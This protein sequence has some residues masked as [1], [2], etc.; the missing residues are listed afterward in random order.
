MR[1]WVVARRDLEN[2]VDE[3]A[4]GRQLF[5]PQ[6]RGELFEFRP[7]LDFEDLCIDYPTTMIPPSRLFAPDGEVLYR[8]DPTDPGRVESVDR[9][10][11]IALFG[12]HP[13]DLEAISVLDELYLTPPVDRNYGNAR[14]GAFI[15]CLECAAPCVEEALCSDK[16]TF[17]PKRACDLQLV[18][19][20]G[21]EYLVRSRTKAGKSLC[22][23]S[24]FCRSAAYEDRRRL[25][26]F[27]ADQARSFRPVF[28]MGA[29]ELSHNVRGSWD[30]L[31][32]VAQSRLCLNCGACNTV[33]PTCH[34]FTTRDT[35]PLSADGMGERCRHWT[36]CQLEEFAAV[37]GGENFRDHRAF[38]LRHRVYK[39]EVYLVDRFGRSGCVGCGRCGHFCPSGIKLV[40]I[41]GQI[42]GKERARA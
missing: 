7:L 8:F 15:V 2:L 4:R 31:L 1:E 40:E 13:C 5:A 21:D 32:W 3:I 24:D 37:A 41:F 36:G 18:P 29:E 28:G 6:R 27:R 22:E 17:L 38:R 33:C 19:L 34:C 11:P 9:D 14:N 10:L 25:D 30:D 35:L 16:E 23:S 42:S 20:S 12:V 26:E 39:K